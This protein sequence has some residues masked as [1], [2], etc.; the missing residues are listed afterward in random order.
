MKKEIRFIRYMD[1]ASKYVIAFA[2]AYA[3]FQIA[4]AIVNHDS[5]FKP[6][7]KI[8]NFLTSIV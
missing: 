6:F 1:A 7:V 5:L 2:I 4:R 3:L 8:G